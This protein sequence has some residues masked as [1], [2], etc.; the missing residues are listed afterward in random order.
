MERRKDTKEMH[1]GRSVSFNIFPLCIVTARKVRLQ[2]LLLLGQIIIE[3]NL[4][5]P[6]FSEAPSVL[7]GR[8][9]NGI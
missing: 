3:A 8:D 4:Q 6:G 1:P 2:P 7:G 5:T 9:T